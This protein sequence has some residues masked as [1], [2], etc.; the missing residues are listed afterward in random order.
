MRQAVTGATRSDVD[1]L[2]LAT[3]GLSSRL[4]D[5]L[6]AHDITLDAWRVLQSLTGSGP[7]AMTA[8]AAAT[9]ITGPTLTRVVD[10]LAERALV[11]RDVDGADRRRVVVHVSDR[12]RRTCRSLAPRVEE[13]ERDGLAALSEREARTLRRLLERITG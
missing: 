11:Y 8:L 3:S 7:Q 5:V 2:R 9:H 6:A 4:E 10:R 12:G 1:L 13:A